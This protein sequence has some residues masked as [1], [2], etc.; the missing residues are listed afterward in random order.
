[1]PVVINQFI[2]KFIVTIATFASLAFA[3]RRRGM[4]IPRF[5]FVSSLMFLAFSLPFPRC[6][7]GFLILLFSWLLTTFW[8]AYYV[9]PLPR[10]HPEFARSR[11]LIWW[12]I[13]RRMFSL[14]PPAYMV[15]GG[16]V[17][18]TIAGVRC[19]YSPVLIR[20]DSVA[21]LRLFVEP[22]R[23]VGNRRVF[24]PDISS[25]Q[26]ET[27]QGREEPGTTICFL[28]CYEDV[29]GAIDLR[30]QRET[31]TLKAITGDGMDVELRLLMDFSLGYKERGGLEFFYDYNP[32]ELLR[33]FYLQ[34]SGEL[35]LVTW[36]KRAF[37]IAQAQ[38]KKV[39]S[40]YNLGDFYGNSH[41]NN[42]S[43]TLENALREELEETFRPFRI[44]LMRVTLKGVPPE[45]RDHFLRNLEVDIETE[46]KPREA[47]AEAVY[48][49]QV[50]EARFKFCQDLVED[51]FNV[52]QKIGKGDLETILAMRVT[53]MVEELAFALAHKGLLSPETRRT[54]EEFG[55]FRALLPGRE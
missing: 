7:L 29:G 48:W 14:H 53:K 35:G 37:S 15:E 1:M 16:N 32:A 36:D 22:S 30:P 20:S 17:E 4:W 6:L 54:L 51:L 50:N 39:I 46:E 52:L 40:H 26:G 8:L 24:R 25:R 44:N 43:E 21:L 12:Y 34:S 10:D 9:T 11:L 45:V 31:G 42:S 13:I 2:V 33:A 3:L 38:L 18:E 27:I 41:K 55:V 47:R 23:V 28:N 19:T 5:F 49:R